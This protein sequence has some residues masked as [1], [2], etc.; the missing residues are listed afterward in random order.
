MRRLANLLSTTAILAFLMTFGGCTDGSAEPDV[1]SINTKPSDESIEQSQGLSDKESRY[2]QDAE[3]LGGFV[4]GD[5]VLPAV[6]DAIAKSDRAQLAGFLAPS[7][8]GGIYDVQQFGNADLQFASI[9]TWTDADGVVSCT[10]EE[11]VDWL[12]NMRSEF[13]ELQSASIKVMQ[14]SPVEYGEFEKQWNGSIKLRLAGRL[15]NGDLRETVVKMNCSIDGIDDDMQDRDEWLLQANAYRAD[16]ATGTGYLMHDVTSSTGVDTSQFRDN[17][18]HVEELPIPFLTGGVYVTDFDKDQLQDL[19]I[20]DL[21]GVFFYRGLPGL[22]FEQVTVDVGLPSVIAN[23]EKAPLGA[24]FADLDNDGYDDLILGQ[25]VNRNDNGMRFRRLTAADTN[26]KLSTASYRYSVVDFDLDGK[27]DIYVVGL[28]VSAEKAQP[29]IG[30]VEGHRNQLWKNLGDWQ[31]EDATDAAGI[32]GS[33]GPTFAAVWYDANGDKWP[34]VMTSI[35]MGQN[36][37]F[38]NNGDGTFRKGELPEGY[39]GFSMGITVSDI[40]NDGLGDPYVANMYSKAGERI[41]GN[42]NPELYDSEIDNLMRDFVTGNEL[43]QNNG[44]G[45]YSRIGQL[46]G[47]NDVGWAYGA[48][49]MDLDGDGLEDMYAPVGFQSVDPNKPDG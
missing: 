34:D 48:T 33:G 26:I 14:M 5:V 3:H 40:N 9:N 38:L 44:D 10:G 18:D 43:Y 20:T 35:E 11:F 25:T 4:F 30:D 49:F 29:W 42:L 7:F 17:W 46:A 6:R 28:R 23:S 16:V 22:K 39:G 2:L 37:Y 13:A 24:M 12:I 36:D 21:N 8:N 27:L 41:L 19:L 1:D 31:F 45:T 47:V 15:E 32:A